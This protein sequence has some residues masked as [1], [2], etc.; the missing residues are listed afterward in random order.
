LQNLIYAVLGVI[1]TVIG[2][3][4]V[5][6]SMNAYIQSK[7][8]E[9]LISKEDEIFDAVK[10]Y[11]STKGY[12]PTNITELVT[13]GFLSSDTA[14]DNGF[15]NPFVISINSATGVVSVSTTIA[16]PS[17]RATYIQNW[18]HIIKP[19]VN[20]TTGEIVS[21]FI[22]PTEIL[23]SSIGGALSQAIISSTAPDVTKFKYWYDTSGGGEAI[24][25]LSNGTD[26]VAVASPSTGGG[27]PA[28]SAA[29]TVASAVSLPTTSV[30]E[31]DIRYVNNT[32]TG[33]ID[34]YTYYGTSWS[35]LNTVSTTFRCPKNWVFIPGSQGVEGSPKGWCV[36]KYE[37][38]PT[39]TTGYTTE[40]SAWNWQNAYDTDLSKKVASLPQNP[41]NRVSS[42]NARSVCSSSHLVDA[43]GDTIAGGYPMKYNVWKVLA[44]NI[45]SNPANWS[46][47]AVGSGYIYSGH[48]DNSPANSITPSTDD[49]NGYANTG[50][51]SGNQ[52]RVLYTSEGNAIWDLS[53]NVWEQM[54]ERQ[55]VG[56]I[57][58]NEY[59]TLTASPFSPQYIMS[60]NWNSTNGI[61]KSNG[62]S[63]S[64]ANI[65]TNGNS[66]LLYGN[67]WINGA[68]TG[69]FASYWGREGLVVRNYTVGVRCIVPADPIIVTENLQTTYP[70]TTGLYPSS[71]LGLL[72]TG[73]SGSY[74]ASD[75]GAYRRGESRSFTSNGDGTIK[76]NVT[77]L[78]WQDQATV[79]N[80]T[81]RTQADS[82][83]YCNNLT[84]AGYDDWVLPSYSQLQSIV[85]FGTSSPTKFYPFLYVTSNL[86]WSS[87]TYA[88]NTS[89][90][91][92]VDFNAGGTAGYGKATSYYA[93]CVRGGQ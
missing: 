30:V 39:V 26:W 32:S 5:M 33:T 83:T 16:D 2:T 65:L 28:V 20:E 58:L 25:K 42:I 87:T 69:L 23:G 54:Y 9:N 51:T 53:G 75:D 57:L 18:R 63:N 91:W 52:K 31:G 14:T 86:Y 7:K 22:L 27:L 77:G 74:T 66:W 34:T 61:G 79:N 71:F 29:N 37:A 24:L 19:T 72:E 85:N 6:P 80:S 76:D 15:G 12:A 36:M 1:L 50:Q 55:S 21:Q 89:N 11:Y 59:T 84:L 43:Y 17:A 73:Q 82:I 3:Y 67:N 64:V 13:A 48:N 56:N 70:P 88:P 81:T 38:T 46:G 78:L 35:L 10:K 44:K 93:R 62:D 60:G 49:S 4:Q 92:V 47:G 41:L 40:F 68:D 8:A 45:A 90:A